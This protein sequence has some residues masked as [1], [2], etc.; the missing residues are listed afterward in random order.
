MLKL[1]FSLR[2]LAE[3]VSLKYVKENSDT[4]WVSKVHVP[5][6][7]RILYLLKLADWEGIKEESRYWAAKGP[8]RKRFSCSTDALLCYEQEK[9]N[10]AYLLPILFTSETAE[11][12][13]LLF[14]YQSEVGIADTYLAE[15][16]RRII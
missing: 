4:Y 9:E 15:E 2:T 1:G 12:I 5:V 7:G 14:Q 6:W 13:A 16:R 10:A 8:S 3:I 11:G